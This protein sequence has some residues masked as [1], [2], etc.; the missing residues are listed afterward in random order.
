VRRVL[1]EVAELRPIGGVTVAR[2]SAP[3]IAAESQPGQFA[4]LRAAPAGRWD[5]LLRRPA[6]IA[7]VEGGDL[8]LWGLPAP[9]RLGDRLDLLGPLGR[10]FAIAPSS[11]SLLLLGRG[12]GLAPL[13]ALADQAAERELAVTLL[14]EFESAERAV[15]PAWMAP[16]VEYQVAT[17]D[18]SL[19]HA[20]SALDL[21]PE[22]LGWADELFAGGAPDLPA[23][24]RR[25][26]G[27]TSKPVQVALSGWRGCGTGLCGGCLVGAGRGAARICRDGPVFGLADLA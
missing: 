19:G 1:A 8:W 2:V 17:D 25:A 7:R 18:G 6:W 26:V 14:A 11:R 5:P 20:G 3:A 16:Q 15:P 23:A 9:A 27:A 22:Y 12:D 10:G 13:L 4:Q 21:L 24:L